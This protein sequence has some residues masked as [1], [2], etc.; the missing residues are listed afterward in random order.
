MTTCTADTPAPNGT[1][2]GRGT[3]SWFDANTGVNGPALIEP[4]AVATKKLTREPGVN[5][6][7]WI[8]KGAPARIT[9]GN[10]LIKGAPGTGVGVGFG[11]GAGVGVGVT[12][13]EAVGV[14]ETLG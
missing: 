2:A 13:G 4:E 8:M 11:V 6:L 1:L 7:P 9:C 3:V 5:P 10:E 14:G 12:R